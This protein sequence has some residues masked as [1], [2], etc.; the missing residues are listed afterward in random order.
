MLPPQHGVDFTF[1]ERI[2]M[3][4]YD[5]SSATIQAG[6]TLTLR[7]YYRVSEPPQAS[8]NLFVHLVPQ[9]SL[10]VLAQADSY[11]TTEWRPT[12][13]WT[14]TEEVYIGRDIQLSLPNDLARGE[15][16]LL[17]GLY[18]YQTGERLTTANGEA[19]RFYSLPLTVE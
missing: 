19:N 15:Y 7:N 8:Y 2:H 10:T 13:L 18:D 12:I 6:D 11:P 4:G 14:D 1:G 5:L 17:F 16:R 3:I 9:D